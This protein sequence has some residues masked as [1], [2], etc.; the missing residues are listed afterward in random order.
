MSPVETT[1]KTQRAFTVL[2][3]LTK[4]LLKNNIK[5]KPQKSLDS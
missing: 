5:K 3:A 1:Q 2:C 4:V